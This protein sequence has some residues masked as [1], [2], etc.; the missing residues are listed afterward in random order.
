MPGDNTVSDETQTKSK[1]QICS[2]VVRHDEKAVNCNKCKFWFHANCI[3]MPNNEYNALK[4]T[5]KVKNSM[6]FC[7][8]CVTDVTTMVDDPTADPVNKLLSRINTLEHTIQRL[9]HLLQVVQSGQLSYDENFDDIIE[10]KVKEYLDESKE[11]D[12]RKMNLIVN[13][14]AES[15]STESRERIEDDRNEV[16]NIFRSLG[17]EPDDISD[18]TVRLG[19]VSERFPNRS[20]L[21]SVKSLKTKGDLMKAQVGFRQRNPTKRLYISP[22]LSPRQREDNKVLVAEFKRR[23]GAGENVKIR[24]GKIVTI[25]EEP[26]T[27]G[28]NRRRAGSNASDN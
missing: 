15:R 25:G 20:L 28:R 14:I 21:I 18:L 26:P 24:S 5:A 10:R 9:E 17:V 22:D 2:V 8:K 4:K 12:K 23:K 7:D 16:K 13:G 11:I 27:E 1:C 19:K 3:N 6:W